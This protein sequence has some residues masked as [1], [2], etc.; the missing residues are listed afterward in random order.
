MNALIT[1]S[2]SGSI[3]EE[4]SILNI[5]ALNLRKSHERPEAS[6]EGITI[7]TN[8]DIQSTIISI[9]K[10]LIDDY[11]PNIVS[12]YDE[13]NVS[14]KVCNTILSYTNYINQKVWKKN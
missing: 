6:E 11:K 4:A 13:D 7:L 14:D 2:D 8:L 1:I 3:N 5:K 10:L 12:D 9:D